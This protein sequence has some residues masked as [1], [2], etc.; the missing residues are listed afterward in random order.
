MRENAERSRWGAFA[1]RGSITAFDALL[2]LACALGL[3]ACAAAPSDGAPAAAGATASAARQAGDEALP[4]LDGA[5]AYTLVEVVS[6]DAAADSLE[7]R[8]LPWDLDGAFAKSGVAAG[9]TGTVSCA[10]L[11]LFPAGIPDGHAVVV[12][13]PAADAGSFPLVACSIEKP[14]WFE[15]RLARLDNA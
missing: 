9:E 14:A 3:A 8:A 4:E 10:Q 13:S 12:A 6:K 2:A 5:F 15:A 1:R 7:V 11:V